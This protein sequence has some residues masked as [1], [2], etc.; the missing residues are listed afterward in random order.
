M[1]LGWDDLQEGTELAAREFGPITRT[2]IVR[3][4]GVSGDMNPIHHD[5]GYAR[6][7]GFPT[8]FS[9]GMFQAGML[10][11][12]ATDLLGAANVRRYAVQ[13]REQLWPDD[14]LVCSASVTRRYEED[15]ERKVDLALL[16]TRAASGR[17]AIV[18]EATF[19][20]S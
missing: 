15:G 11:T 16:G 9:A 7:A 10:A 12:F 5:E 18:A 13:F 17:A 4:V 1:T 14:V 3:Y 19:V 8:V 6:A 2:D 20:V